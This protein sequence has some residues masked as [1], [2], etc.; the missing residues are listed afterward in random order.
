VTCQNFKKMVGVSVL[1]IVFQIKCIGYD[2]TFEFRA[3]RL[4]CRLCQIMIIWS[5]IRAPNPRPTHHAPHP[6]SAHDTSAAPSR[7]RDVRVSIRNGSNLCVPC[8]LRSYCDL[9]PEKRALLVFIWFGSVSL[10]SG[11][12]TG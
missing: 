10:W 7:T 8:D 11:S 6:R 4:E 2:S 12:E 1:F 9:R 5:L 3:G